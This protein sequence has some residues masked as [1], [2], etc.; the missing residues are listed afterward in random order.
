MHILLAEDDPKLGRLIHYRLEKEAHNVDWAQDGL[1]AEAYLDGSEYDLIILDW[2]MPEKSG[3]ELCRQLRAQGDHTPVL[4]LTA[5]DA[6]QDRVQG[7]DAGA[8][9]Y[10]IKPF[11]FEELLARI[12]ALGR[13]SVR[14]WQDEV[15]TAGDLTL[16]LRTYEVTR[17][18]K[19]ILLTKREYQLLAYLM[20]NAGQTLTREMIMDAVWGLDAD[21]TP[22]T[23]DAYI[24]LLRKKVDTPQ[25]PKRIQSV[26]GL[27]YRLVGEP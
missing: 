6:V 24:S 17:N 16:N 12:R 20:K 27:G 26:R 14:S 3:M 5:K 13:R 7:L 21:V 22:N 2:M 11:A 23:V 4:M 10:L 15:L 25:A 8:D 9:D 19:P 18:G 1:E